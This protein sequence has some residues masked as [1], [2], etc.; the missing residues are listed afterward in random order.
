MRDRLAEL[1]QRAH[2][3]SEA[4]SENTSPLSEEGDD[5]ESAA[6]EVITP[7]AVLFEEEPIIENF[8]SEAKKIRDDITALETEVGSFVLFALS[9][10]EIS[11]EGKS[12]SCCSVCFTFWRVSGL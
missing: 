5:D 6:V 11:R 9:Y 3:F 7:Q 12:P 10:T 8:L 1:Q 2:D 4:A